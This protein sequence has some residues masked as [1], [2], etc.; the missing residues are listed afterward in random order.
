MSIGTLLVRADANASIGAGHV[1]RCLALAQAWQDAGGSAIFA[2][3]EPP[4]SIHARLQG[5]GIEVIQLPGIAGTLD[6]SEQTSRCAPK[7]EANWLVLDGYHFGADYELSLKR[8]G[9]R[10][11]SVDDYGQLQHHSAD[12]VLDQNPQ[13]P[14]HAYTQTEADCKLLLGSKYVLLRREFRH[15]SEWERVIPN[16][17]CSV[18]ITMGGSDPDNLTGHAL[19]ALAAAQIDDLEV[20]VVIGGSNPHSNPLEV[21]EPEMRSRVRLL[22]DAKEMAQIMCA[23]DVAIIAAGGTLWESLFMQCAVL[24]YAR[25]PVQRAIVENLQDEGAAVSLGGG[26][27]ADKA[28]TSQ[29]LRELVRS[30]EQRSKLSKKGRELIDGLG[31]QRVVGVMLGHSR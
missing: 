19:Q 25:N 21:V 23:S 24:S 22:T 20:T 16:S 5:E 9:H 28:H 26:L 30:Y 27:N 8:A 10:L 7:C 29:L 31:A 11:L 18:L 15:W 3:V 14:S 4:P 2:M 12:I 17:G 6:D 13:V 1:M